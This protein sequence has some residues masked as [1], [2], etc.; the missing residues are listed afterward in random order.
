MTKFYNEDLQVCGLTN[1]DRNTCH[2]CCSVISTANDNNYCYSNQQL[3]YI[4]L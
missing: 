1:N 4:S 2:E 3:F